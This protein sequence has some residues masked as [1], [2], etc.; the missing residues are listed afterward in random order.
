MAS[1]LKETNSGEFLKLFTCMVRNSRRTFIRST[2]LTSAG[3]FIVNANVLQAKAINEKKL[4][5]NV[6]LIE[7]RITWAG[8]FEIV[9]Q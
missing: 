2:A 9:T 5:V 7:D 6:G 3:A 1:L 8:P 4:Q